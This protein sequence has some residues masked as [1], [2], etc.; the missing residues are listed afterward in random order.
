MPF[1]IEQSL[2][3]GT[4]TL[5]LAQPFREWAPFWAFVTT[6]QRQPIPGHRFPTTER[7][8]ENRLRIVAARAGKA[9]ASLPEPVLVEVRE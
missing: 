7:A 4:I 6:G 8:E 1:V 2:C 3:D 9:D 5:R